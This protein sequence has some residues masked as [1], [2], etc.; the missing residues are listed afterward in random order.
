M[1]DVPTC[2][3]L[4][5]LADAAANEIAPRRIVD[6]HLDHLRV[7]VPL[8]RALPV[9]KMLSSAGLILGARSPRIGALTSAALV[10][11]Y[12]AAVGYHRN[13]GDHPAVAAPA[14]LF[15]ATAA[16]A[17]FGVFLPSVAD[18]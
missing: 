16:T 1:T 6:K 4:L 5:Q 10:A 8:R 12:A 13:A 14:A 15:G 11:Y 9:I 3:A 17:L 2:L 7:P 18:R